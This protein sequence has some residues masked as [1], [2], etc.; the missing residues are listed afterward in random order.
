MRHRTRTLRSAK[1]PDRTG[2]SWCGLSFSDGRTSSGA[3]GV[4]KVRDHPHVPILLSPSDEL[5]YIPRHQHL[6][7][8][9]ESRVVPVRSELQSEGAV[10]C[11]SSSLLTSD[12]NAADRCAGSRNGL[13]FRASSS[14]WPSHASGKCPGATRPNR[15][16]LD[17]RLLA[18]P[19]ACQGRR[20]S[21]AFLRLAGGV[22]LPKPTRR[23]VLETRIDLPL[24]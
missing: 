3:C 19:F 21:G 16:V 11:V 23:C 10:H 18:Q 1:R 9:S 22:C 5:Y 13:C 24:R 2:P 6:A 4:K 15:Q 12:R 7:P 14:I 17:A 8:R 20:T